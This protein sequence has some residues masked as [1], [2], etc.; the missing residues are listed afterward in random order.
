M[1]LVMRVDRRHGIAVAANEVSTARNRSQRIRERRYLLQSRMRSID[2]LL[3][4]LEARNLDGMR[5]IDAAIRAELDRL[6]R[7]VGVPLPCDVKLARNTRR[8]HAA[9][10]DWQQQVL[11][12]L[13]PARAEY[14]DV[15][16]IFDVDDALRATRH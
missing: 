8:L 6:P 16:A 14:A 13:V 5:E 10:L 4:V 15:D 2:H 9:L 1:R 3:E 7:A 12:L 11:D